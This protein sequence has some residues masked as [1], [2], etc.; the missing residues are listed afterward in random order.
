MNY[1][2]NLLKIYLIYFYVTEKCLK[3]NIKLQA[4]S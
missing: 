2:K 3:E 4:R 1:N